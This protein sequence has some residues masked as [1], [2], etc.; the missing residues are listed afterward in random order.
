MRTTPSTLP[1]TSAA[2]ASRFHVSVLLAGFEKSRIGG[3]AP[4]YQRKYKR[5]IRIAADYFKTQD[6]REIRKLHVINFRDHLQQSFVWKGKTLKNVLDLFK[7]FMNYAKSEL[8]VITTVPAFPMIE[9]EDSPFK[10]VG[11]EAQSTLFE[12]VADEDKPIIAFVMLHG[13]RPGEARALKLKDVDLE[14]GSVTIAAT[15]SD[16][17]YREKRKGRRSRALVMPIHPEMLGCLTECKRN[18]HPE[19]F[20]FPNPRT[21]DPY[22]PSG[23]LRVWNA[24]RKALNISDLKL[25]QASRH[26]Y[27]SQLVNSG[28]SLF[29]VSRLLGHSSMKTTEKYAHAD[30]DHLRVEIGKITLKKKET[31]TRLSL[32]GRGTD[33]KA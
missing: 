24:V 9:A 11:P 10:W 29:K 3:I 20:V 18:S 5:M 8:E 19:A 1:S 14:S 26:S 30:L 28:V 16:N 32:E 17:T 2:E 6:I 15:F 33:E 31:V 21:G 25:Y 7:T 13:C 22:S 27:A 4:S 23:L 12:A